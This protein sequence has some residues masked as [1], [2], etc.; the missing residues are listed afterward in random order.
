MVGPFGGVCG[1]WFCNY[2]CLTEL[3]QFFWKMGHPHSSPLSDSHPSCLPTLD[4]GGQKD[5]RL[6]ARSWPSAPRSWCPCCPLLGR[7]PL[8]CSRGPYPASG[9]LPSSAILRSWLCSSVSSW[10]PSGNTPVW[11]RLL[12]QHPLGCCCSVVSA[13]FIHHCLSHSQSFCLLP[14]LSST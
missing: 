6:W 3:W 13:S 10:P 9:L 4:A 5:A 14:F 1:R 12:E 7:R 8:T 11:P 2:V